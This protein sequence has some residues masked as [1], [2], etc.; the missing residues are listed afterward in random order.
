MKYCTCMGQVMV[1]TNSNWRKY[2]AHFSDT[3]KNVPDQFGK[4]VGTS[5]GEVVDWEQDDAMTELGY[6]DDRNAR[7]K[8]KRKI[9]R[10]KNQDAFSITMKI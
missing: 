7:K 8:M 1:F 6:L 4:V 3:G 10:I 5:E 9:D 2:L